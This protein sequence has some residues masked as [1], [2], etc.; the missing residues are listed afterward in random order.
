MLSS[1]VIIFKTFRTLGKTDTLKFFEEI[2]NP[3]ILIKVFFKVIGFSFLKKKYTRLSPGERL[4]DALSKLG[5]AFI[6]LGQFLATRPD[7]VGEKF[8]K[9]LQKLQDEMKPFD[10]EIAKKTLLNELG[11]NKFKIS[12]VRLQPLQLHRFILQK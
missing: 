6:K 9:E 1:L 7:I 12:Q 5:P 2:Y 10:T 8:A 4:T 3:P 11:E